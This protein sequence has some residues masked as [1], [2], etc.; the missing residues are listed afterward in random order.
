MSL[1]NEKWLS[2]FYHFH[3]LRA[4]GVDKPDPFSVDL[5]ERNVYVW[6]TE[7]HQLREDL[8]SKKIQTD[9]SVHEKVRVLE[10]IPDFP[11]D[12]QRKTGFENQVTA[13]FD[14]YNKYGHC[15]IPQA[16]PNGLG[17]FVA[18]IRMDHKKFIA[19]KQSKLNEQLVERLESIGFKWSGKESSDE[20]WE[21]KYNMLLN[22]K[23]RNGHCDVPRSENPLGRWV[24]LQRECRRDGKI[25]PERF[26]KLNSIGFNWSIGKTEKQK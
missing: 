23:E 17:S 9:E 18:R 1:P 15:A 24:S 19:G 2:N 22:F 21:E 3:R 11:W 16:T 8:R 20:A 12:T 14:F 4:N 26:V 5:D 13:I 6:I 10:A 7:Q 25:L